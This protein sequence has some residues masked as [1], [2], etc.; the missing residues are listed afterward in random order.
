MAEGDGTASTQDWASMMNEASRQAA[1][2]G[3][4]APYGMTRDRETGE[5]RPKKTRGRPKPSPSIEELR[6]AKDQAAADGAPEAPSADRPPAKPA[7]GSRSR[8]KTPPG[9]PA[10]P[11]P[12]HRPGIITKGVNR[13]YRRAGKIVK[14]MDRDIGIAVIESTKNTAEDG[15]PDDSVGAAWDELARTNPRIRVFLLRIIAGGAWGQLVMAHAPI[16]MA[17]VM[18]DGIRKHIPFMKLIEALAADDDEG[19]VDGVPVPGG[20]GGLLAGMRPEDMQQMAAMAQRMMGQ[21]AAGMADGP[22]AA[23]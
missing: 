23:A 1:P 13:L 12:Q 11:V 5:L 8:I 22:A 6:A 20:L 15:E 21:T 10:E 2:E 17:I 19:A 9:T 4:A 16:A 7:R 18:K 14:A 3:D